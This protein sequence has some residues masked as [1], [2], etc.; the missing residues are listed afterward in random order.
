MTNEVKNDLGEDNDI[1]MT[2][3]RDDDDEYMENEDK[4]F[5]YN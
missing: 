3:D 2:Y 5:I 1:L 4:G